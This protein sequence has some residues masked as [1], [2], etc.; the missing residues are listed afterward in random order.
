MTEFEEIYSANFLDVY[1][2]AFSLCQNRNL[3]EEIT[4]ET[5]FKALKGIDKFNGHC[6]L[7]VWLCQKDYVGG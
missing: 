1:K 6:K 3:A 2:Y 5:F 4:Q 7:R